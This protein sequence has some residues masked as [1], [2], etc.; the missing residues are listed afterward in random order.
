MELDSIEGSKEPKNK[1]T[2]ET[3]ELKKYI[4]EYKYL[5]DLNL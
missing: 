3:K 1:L 2:V 4:D 5:E